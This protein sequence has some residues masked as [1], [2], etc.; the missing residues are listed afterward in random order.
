LTIR[1]KEAGR[2]AGSR[3]QVHPGMPQ[4]LVLA[5]KDRRPRMGLEIFKKQLLN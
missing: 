4:P 3:D 1:N 2:Q 5:F